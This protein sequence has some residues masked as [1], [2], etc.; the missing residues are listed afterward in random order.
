MPDTFVCHS[1]SA[2]LAR[3]EEAAKRVIMLRDPSAKQG[4]A[5]G[6]LVEAERE[7]SR[8]TAQAGE[9]QLALRAERQQSAALKQ[10]V[11]ELQIALDRAG[12]DQRLL[13]RQLGAAEVSNLPTRAVNT[14]CLRMAGH[15]L[16][17][18][19][20]DMQRCS[21]SACQASQAFRLECAF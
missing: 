19:T 14:A 21:C 20:T 5:A 18:K 16:N 10:K 6:R 9:A 3:T 7:L 12:K 8:A 15:A 17:S 13:A 2:Q 4:G 1:L 11:A